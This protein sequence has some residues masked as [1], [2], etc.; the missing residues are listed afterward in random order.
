M[1][2]VTKKPDSSSNQPEHDDLTEING[3]SN[4]RAAALNQ[5]NIYQFSQLSQT[6]PEALAK[7]LQE[8]TD[9]HITAKQI[10]AGDWIGQATILARLLRGAKAA[11]GIIEAGRTMIEDSSAATPAGKNQP[12]A[13]DWQTRASFKVVFNSRTD[14]ENTSRWQTRVMEEG[15]GDKA[16]LDGIATPPWVSWILAKAQFPMAPEL[17]PTTAPEG[18]A[19][20]PQVHTP[21]TARNASIEICKIAVKK[22]QPTSRRLAGESQLVIDID[23]KLSGPQVQALI[24]SQTKYLALVY[25]IDLQTRRSELGAMQE[26]YL[27]PLRTEYNCQLKC[28]IPK[29]GRYDIQSVILLPPPY[30]LVDLYQGDTLKVI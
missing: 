16:E 4:T 20:Q 29:V 15:S 11:Q 17:I 2:L 7:L 3:I 26:E 5:L 9:L 14:D 13:V 21:K 8:Q 10:E 28:A 23:F 30:F 22:D 1:A 27:D 6:T 19:D 24:A 25:M 12:D 18:S